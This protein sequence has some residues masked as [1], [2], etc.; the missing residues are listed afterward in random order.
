MKQ[1]EIIMEKLTTIV[2]H[3]LVNENSVLGYSAFDLSIDLSINRANISKQLNNLWKDNKLI[4]INGRPTLYLPVDSITQYY[5]LK[6][7][8]TYF[9]SY[10]DFDS[11]LK[12]DLISST[13]ESSPQRTLDN[14]Q[15]KI[16]SDL[17]LPIKY[18]PP[19]LLFDDSLDRYEY[20]F[21][22][23]EAYKATD[24]SFKNYTFLYLDSIILENQLI[25]ELLSYSKSSKA[26]FILIDNIQYL[27][28]KTIVK[29]NAL[30]QTFKHSSIY[31]NITLLFSSSLNLEKTNLKNVGNIY[32]APKYTQ[33]ST[34]EKLNIII[35]KIKLISLKVNHDI[36]IDK[37]LFK[38]FCLNIIDTHPFVI[39]RSVSTAVLK[40]ASRTI[41]KENESINLSWSDFDFSLIHSNIPK[42]SPLN[43]IDSY[44]DNYVQFNRDG[45][46]RLDY[47]YN[48]PI[49]FKLVKLIT[50]CDFNSKPEI[51][52]FLNSYIES[53]KSAKSHELYSLV[54]NSISSNKNIK[55]PKNEEKTI[56]LDFLVTQL[57]KITNKPISPDNI[58]YLYSTYNQNFY[59]SEEEFDFLLLF[60][61]SRHNIQT[62]K[63]ILEKTNLN[64]K[65]I[66]IKK[67]LSIQEIKN[68]VLNDIKNKN[69]VI[70]TDIHIY[71]NIDQILLSSSDKE[72]VVFYPLSL[73][74]L[75]NIIEKISSHSITKNEK[76]TV[77]LHQENT[78]ITYD[79]SDSKQIFINNLINRFLEPNLTFLDPFKS[80][81]ALNNTLANILQELKLSHNKQL[82]VKFLVHSC[83]MIER[84]IQKQYFDYDNLN[85]H[86]NN[87]LE[88]Y[89]I[90]KKE[91]HNIEEIFGISIPPSEIGYLID[92]FIETKY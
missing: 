38:I 14:L 55:Q 70:I 73:P 69:I 42:Y 8:P 49:F 54:M 60:I 35:Q 6:F 31:K 15:Q 88:I 53:I 13:N 25:D 12:P 81:S 72:Y 5:N 32:E 76:N 59:Y 80:V 37:E 85:Y 78:F 66:Q 83:F 26:Y 86:L 46:S 47:I 91:F 9:A 17:L 11:Y 52:I 87:N 82:V 20:I 22:I 3:Q 51:D 18:F 50:S 2:D 1:I 74:L 45:S 90:I 29:L 28:Q 27:S 63:Q 62:Y 36:K 48:Q 44:F 10:L 40:A 39:E 77:F 41:H 68:N 30:L 16:L 84:C 34:L 4:K 21:P 7:I 43:I 65:I 33:L 24:N 64:H 71:R 67:P 19:L 89:T 23:Y 58:E 56:G 61:D 75:E 79:D 92:I 57:N